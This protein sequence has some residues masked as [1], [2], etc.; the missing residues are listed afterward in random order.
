MRPPRRAY[1][2]WL[3]GIAVICM[4]EWHVL[5]AWTTLPARDG[6]AWAVI[7]VIGGFAAPLFLFLAGVAVPLA[8]AGHRSR[9]AGARRAAWLVQKRGWEVFGLAH[10]FRLQSF[11]LNPNA[12]WSGILKP[13]ILNVL[14]LGLA[15]TAWLV[16]RGGAPGR[17]AWWLLLPAAIVLFLTPSSRHWWWPTLLHPRLEAY[18]RPNPFGVFA[19]FPW[20]AY[21]PF[22]AF[23]G[24]LI[25][26]P[27]ADEA[28]ERRLHRQFAVYGL[29]AAVAGFA[30]AAV[31]LPGAIAPAAA[32]WA[33]FLSF[34]GGMTAAI[35]LAWVWM[36]LPIAAASSGPVVLF[37]RTSLFVYWVHVELAYGVLSYPLHQA[38]PLWWSIPG[39]LAVTGVMYVAAEWW[40]ARPK[41]PW[42][43]QR[44]RSA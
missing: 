14:G 4:I 2:D 43:P 36:R 3:R 26:D 13:D 20:V 32:V 23:I 29:A 44:L 33:R 41:G 22:G 18:I 19:L 24:A 38:L 8:I 27:K 42:I 9:G 6:W 21:V 28:Q 5:D 11:L 34:A 10:L 1:L 17:R 40:A 30:L 37:G 12:K 31:P 25:A 35:W 16:G 7:K 39:F 15:G